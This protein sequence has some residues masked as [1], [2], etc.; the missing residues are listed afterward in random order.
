MKGGEGEGAVKTMP[1]QNLFIVTIYALYS[2][3]ANALIIQEYKP[4][5]SHN[6]FLTMPT[7]HFLQKEWQQRSMRGS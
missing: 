4:N 1:C 5:G 6:R 2:I 7:R 3:I